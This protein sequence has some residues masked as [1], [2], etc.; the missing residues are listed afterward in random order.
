MFTG[1]TFLNG[2][3]DEFRIYYG[4]LTASQV[5]TNFAAGPDVVVP[6]LQ[7]PAM[8]AILSGGNVVLSWPDSAI[9][10]GLESSVSLGAAANW[11]PVS[12][13]PTD[14]NG[15]FTMTLSTSGSGPT[16]FRLRK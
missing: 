12:G 1:D 13:T 4:A 10:F 11:T 3:V 9:G 15:K 7:P 2:T 6:I 14:I 5:A 8:D 16:F